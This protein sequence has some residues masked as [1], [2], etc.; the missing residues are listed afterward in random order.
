ML[1]EFARDAARAIDEWKRT[2]GPQRLQQYVREVLQSVIGIAQ[3]LGNVAKW[4]KENPQALRLAKDIGAAAIGARVG[5]M[6]GPWGALVGGI[7]GAG[8]AEFAGA[9]G[10]EPPPTPVERQFL[11]QLFSRYEAGANIDRQYILRS[12]LTY[13]ERGAISHAEFLH[14]YRRWAGLGARPRAAAAGT[15]FR[16]RPMPP[17]EQQ[18]REAERRRREQQA[19][20]QRASEMSASLAVRQADARLQDAMRD[21]SAAGWTPQAVARVRSAYEAWKQ[22]SL[23]AASARAAGEP[24][25]VARQLIAEAQFEVSERKREI[26]DAIQRG[27]QEAQQESA[28]QAQ[29]LI[30]YRRQRVAG[31]LGAPPHERLYEA[32]TA[33]M[34]LPAQIAAAPFA[35]VGQ[36]M[37][38]VTLQA[39]QERERAVSEQMRRFGEMVGQAA[40]MEERRRALSYQ[41]Y[42]GFVAYGTPWAQA[43]GAPA[44][45]AG[46]ARFM[47]GVLSPITQALVDAVAEAQQ[48][49]REEWQQF[50]QDMATYTSNSV[51]D[52][53]VRLTMDFMDNISRWEDAL[54]DF[55]RSIKQMIQRAIAEWIYENFIKQGVESLLGGLLGRAQKGGGGKPSFG[56]VLGGVILS[57][58]ISW[59][60]GQIFPGLGIFQHGGTALPG[61]LA[62]VGERGPELIVPGV[63][64]AVVTTEAVARALA[65]L[66]HSTAPPQMN[67]Y[68]NHD[69]DLGLAMRVGRE[70]ERG[71]RRWRY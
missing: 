23:R 44:P 56:Q 43:F 61:R 17:S 49:I 37:L 67:I 50:W 42:Q 34:P 48:R 31:L 64:S 39:A 18:M 38:R 55:V 63:T 51:R 1:A 58:A 24:T 41:A 26:E 40:A 33:M 69:G 20:A 45:L 11:E 59:G 36:E 8:A 70:V 62:L 35:P 2:G 19:I 15:G 25:P 10:R 65:N 16:P 53:F 9:S 47:T 21:A 27:M 5:G 57:A 52:A 12:M 60:L 7:V 28:R 46:A 13:Y 32:F 71:L 22:A 4:F 3:W 6:F 54:K 29:E 14:Y 66:S 68:V 30:E